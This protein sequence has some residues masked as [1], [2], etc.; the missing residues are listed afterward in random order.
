[1]GFNSGFKGLKTGCVKW[2]IKTF[3]G[4]AASR[5]KWEK[6]GCEKHRL[7]TC[8]A[9]LTHDKAYSKQIMA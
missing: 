8:H 4:W 9:A 5:M 3:K 7:S 2:G 1:M 6:R